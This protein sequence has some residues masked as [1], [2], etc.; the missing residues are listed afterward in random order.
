[1]RTHDTFITFVYKLY[2]LHQQQKSPVSPTTPSKDDSP[3]AQS[4][5]SS[6]EENQPLAAD[7]VKDNA[8]TSVLNQSNIVPVDSNPV[9]SSDQ[10]ENKPVDILQQTPAD[11]QQTT[12]QQTTSSSPSTPGDSHIP[13][14]NPSSTPVS[15]GESN[16]AA[17]KLDQNGHVSSVDGEDSTVT[18]EKSGKGWTMPFS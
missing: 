4:N 15:I 8:V 5:S 10:T 6:K 16:S 1:M 18:S 7:S 9:A 3:V 13:L 12:P 2:F 11:Q 14:S 17:D